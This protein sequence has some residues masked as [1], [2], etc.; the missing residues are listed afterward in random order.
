MQLLPL[1]HFVAKDVLQVIVE[2]LEV[3]LKRAVQPEHGVVVQRCEVFDQLRRRVGV[4]TLWKPDVSRTHNV[5]EKVVRVL[6]QRLVFADKVVVDHARP[7]QPVDGR[8]ML[9]EHRVTGVGHK[10]GELGERYVVAVTQRLLSGVGS[11]P[12]YDAPAEPRL[13]VPRTVLVPLLKL[14]PVCGQQSLERVPDEQELGVRG[15]HV[16]RPSRRVVAQPVQRAGL[17]HHV[18]RDL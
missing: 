9:V 2:Q 6:E 3:E 10:R 14:V 11:V 4:G 7:A 15:Q 5:P 8:P 17:V 1:A 12:P 13:K 18:R 16:G